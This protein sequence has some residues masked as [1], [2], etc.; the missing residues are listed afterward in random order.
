MSAHTRE[1][2]MRMISPRMRVVELASLLLM[3]SIAAALWP[4]PLFGQLRATLKVSDWPNSGDEQ[5]AAAIDIIRSSEAS[6]TKCILGP[7]ILIMFSLV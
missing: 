1:K 5:I 3:T 2:L 6:L 7:I 4:S